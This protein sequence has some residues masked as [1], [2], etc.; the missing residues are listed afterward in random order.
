VT[1]SLGLVIVL[2]LAQPAA[3]ICVVQPIDRLVKGSDDVWWGAVTEATA[4]PRGSPGVWELTVRIDD[5]LKGEGTPGDTY[6]VLTSTCGVYVSRQG[7]K[8]DA[9][10]LH[11]SA[12]PL[13]GAWRPPEPVRGL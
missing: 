10:S 3:A 4:A 12:T 6:T 5:V 11:M 13:L 9:A 1:T 8:E 2:A 7:A